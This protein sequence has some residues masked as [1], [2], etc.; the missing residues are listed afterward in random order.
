MIDAA[1]AAAE[2]CGGLD[3][4]RVRVFRRGD[5]GFGLRIE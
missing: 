4:D 5:G 2:A 1:A 3:E